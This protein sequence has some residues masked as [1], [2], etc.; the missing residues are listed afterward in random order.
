MLQMTGQLSKAKN[1]DT[2][3][4]VYWE[5]AKRAHPYATHDMLR[6]WY[7]DILTVLEEKGNTFF[8]RYEVRRTQRELQ[9]TVEYLIQTAREMLDPD[10]PLYPNPSW[11]NCN[12]CHFRSPCLM[13]NAGGDVEFVL[14]EEYQKRVAY[15]ETVKKLE[16]EGDAS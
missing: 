16:G 5:A 12:F 13:M 15:D 8:S 9:E 3:L 4:E 7:A 14:N 6:E 10:T 11:M 1:I 2:T